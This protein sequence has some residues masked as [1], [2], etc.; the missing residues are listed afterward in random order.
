MPT[1]LKTILKLHVPVIVLVG[2][3][4]LS[5][6]DVLSLGPGAIVE[7]SKSSDENLAF[8]INNKPVGQGVAVKVGEN[9]GI[10]ILSIGTVESRIKAMAG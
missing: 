6:D 10:R 7:L 1:E 5:V 4:R 3:R 2:D 9:F 8:L